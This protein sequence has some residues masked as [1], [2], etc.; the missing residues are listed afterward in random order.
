[1][2]RG[3]PHTS[4]KE[5]WTPCPR[6]KG[7]AGSLLVITFH[8]CSWQASFTARKLSLLSSDLNP[9]FIF[10]ERWR[11]LVISYIK[12]VW[13]FSFAFW[14]WLNVIIY[15]PLYFVM[16]LKLLFK[17]FNFKEWGKQEWLKVFGTK[18]QDSGF[19]SFFMN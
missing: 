3:S 12:I 9:S 18:L 8:T 16:N 11:L 4:A 10:L 14:P 19:H 13:Y 7:P 2:V 17:N 15:F 5:L 1:M 6:L